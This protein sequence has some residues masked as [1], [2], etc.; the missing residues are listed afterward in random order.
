MTNYHKNP[1]G[2]TCSKAI[3][4]KQEEPN[5]VSVNNSRLHEE[6]DEIIRSYTIGGATILD[7]PYTLYVSFRLIYSPSR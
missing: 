5:K 6:N 2:S 1:V 7:P 4:T 3:Y